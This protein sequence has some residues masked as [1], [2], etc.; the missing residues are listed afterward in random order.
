[1][2]VSERGG[3]RGEGGSTALEFVILAPLLVLLVLF[4]LWAGRSGRAGLVTDLAAKEAA[5]AAALCCEEGE[6]ERR[7]RVLEKVLEAHPGL[8]P[9]CLGGVRPAGE[10]YVSEASMYF[11]PSD[12]GSA[13]GVGV[14]SVGVECDTEGMLAPLLGLFPVVTVEG[15]ASEVVSL[16]SPVGPSGLPRLEV[17]DARA[18]EGDRFMTFDVWLHR[19][20]AADVSVSW[21]IV[22]QVGQA[23]A[24]ADYAIVSGVA[25][26]FPGDRT[27]EVRVPLIDDTL[28]EP[29][30]T[31]LLVL[32]NPSGA[33]LDRTAA[34]GTIVD[35]D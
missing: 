29:D 15:R 16:S 24:G 5:T 20:R 7:E 30:E 33:S 26:V 34:V 8:D 25:R 22:A 31:F 18:S 17:D 11:D 35:D 3:D 23:A 13:G 2:A 9:L 28:D 10:R 21:W 27:A 4:V 14:L 12:G 1:M 19:P 32:G 6:V